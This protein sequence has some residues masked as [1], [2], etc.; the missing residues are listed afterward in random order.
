MKT[1]LTLLIFFV[2]GASISAQVI[3]HD[4][5]KTIIPFLQKEDYKTAFEKSTDLLNTTQN[6]SSDIRGIVTYINIFSA[7]GMVT[8]DQMTHADFIK[9]SKRFVGQHVVMSAHLC[10]D[11]LKQS[12]NALQ[13]HF[14]DGEIQG[15]T[16]SSNDAKTTIL[17]FEYF[18]YS[19]PINPAE[20]IGNNVRCGGTLTS[21]DVNPNKSKI[22]V[23]RLHI[24]NAFARIMTPL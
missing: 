7:A 12:F 11:S 10:V 15:S 3:S 14:K 16:T 1:L 18:K 21:I 6:D 5:F 4:D 20:F 17:C 8:R 9:N 24:S 22:W 2:F 23:S 19:E 13:F